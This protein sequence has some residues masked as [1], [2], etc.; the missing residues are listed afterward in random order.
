MLVID[1]LA[2]RIVEINQLTG[3]PV[4]RFKQEVLFFQ[5]PIDVGSAALCRPYRTHQSD[6]FIVQLF[7][8]ICRIREVERFKI[9]G[10][11]HGIISPILPVLHN[12]VNREITLAV[13]V[14]HLMQFFKTGIAF[15]ALPESESSFRKHRCFTCQMSVT[16]ND[17]VRCLSGYEIII[18]G[19]L[20]RG[21][22]RHVV[23]FFRE[24]AFGIKIPK[25]SI[26]IGRKHERNNSNLIGLRQQQFFTSIIHHSVL[27]LSQS[28]KRLHGCNLKVLCYTEL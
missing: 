14:H 22:E 4:S 9:H 21:L 12:I 16:G 28:I 8:V 1:L 2:F 27:K 18:D 15:L 11:P 20:V 13:V 17:L 10:R 3:T 19:F 25:Q 6:V 5:F 26:L 23:L 7:D 24:Q